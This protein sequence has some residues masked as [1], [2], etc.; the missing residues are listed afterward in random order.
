MEHLPFIVIAIFFLVGS[1]L[2]FRKFRKKDKQ[3]DF[4]LEDPEPVNIVKIGFKA[5]TEIPSNLDIQNYMIL[6]TD[7]FFEKAKSGSVTE[8]EV[9]EF[10]VKNFESIRLNYVFEAQ[11][12]L[13]VNNVPALFKSAAKAYVEKKPTPK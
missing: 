11:R 6:Y 1:A 13:M 3:K 12:V 5:N 4:Y 7:K 2:L 10:F 8:Q 9:F